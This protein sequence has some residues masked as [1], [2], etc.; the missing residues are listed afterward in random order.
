M[1]LTFLIRMLSYSLNNIQSRNF[2]ASSYLFSFSLSLLELVE[3]QE[4]SR[5]DHRMRVHPYL[6]LQC[7]WSFLGEIPL[8]QPTKSFKISR[9]VFELKPSRTQ[10]EIVCGLTREA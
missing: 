6:G 8:P 10:D 1:K 7:L 9:S 5:W 3:A 2:S 4:R